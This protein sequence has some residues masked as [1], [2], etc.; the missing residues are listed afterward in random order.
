[1]KNY[2]VLMAVKKSSSSPLL[3]RKKEKAHA[4]SLITFL[5]EKFKHSISLTTILIQP[6]P[7]KSLSFL[8]DYSMSDIVGKGRTSNK[9]ATATDDAILIN[10]NTESDS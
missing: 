4:Y 8:S 9:G 2:R 1:M 10:D 7:E 3:F 5:S 6:P